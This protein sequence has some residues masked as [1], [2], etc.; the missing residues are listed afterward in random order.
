VT[1]LNLR[2]RETHLCSA[3]PVFGKVAEDAV[4]S[5]RIRQHVFVRP[6][7]R[8]S[9]KPLRRAKLP[10]P[11]EDVVSAKGRQWSDLLRF[12]P[13]STSSF[14]SH[15]HPAYTRARTPPSLRTRC[16]RTLYGLLI[17][18]RVL[19][20]ASRYPCQ[21]VRQHVLKSRTVRSSCPEQWQRTDT[22]VARGKFISIA[23]S[24]R[25][26][27]GDYAA[28]GTCDE[29][30]RESGLV[31]VGLRIE[32]AGGSLAQRHI[33][34]VNKTSILVCAAISPLPSA[35]RLQDCRNIHSHKPRPNSLRNL[36]IFTIWKPKA[37][38]NMA[39]CR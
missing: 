23:R 25:P 28:G 16:R 26:E 9:G 14:P 22:E 11:P 24:T 30:E 1:F 4:S 20:R 39:A 10:Q 35:D 18:A 38:R 5:D 29:R 7:E 15:L 33:V 31:T 8:G 21:A 12:H 27:G 17:V 6:E 36:A 34:H 37:R 19:S 13:I 2:V 32:T 3:I